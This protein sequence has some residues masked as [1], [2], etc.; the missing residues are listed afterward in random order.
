MD[1]TQSSAPGVTSSC[2]VIMTPTCALVKLNR[3]SSLCSSV[4]LY[5][6]TGLYFPSAPAATQRLL[7]LLLGL[8]EFSAHA[9]V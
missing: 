6:F 7:R 4:H 3:P 2:D 1:M 9:T 8:P 5:I